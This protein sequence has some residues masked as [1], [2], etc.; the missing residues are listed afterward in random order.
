M[1]TA[2]VIGV[3]GQD[4]VYLAG[5]LTDKGYDVVGVTRDVL[6]AAADMPAALLSRS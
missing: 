4:G 5:L 3:T 2:M 6:K 1:T